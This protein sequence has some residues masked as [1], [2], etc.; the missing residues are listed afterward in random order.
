MFTDTGSTHVDLGSTADTAPNTLELSNAELNTISGSGTTFIGVVAENA[1]VVTHAINLGRPADKTLFLFGAGGISESGAGSVTV[2][3][4]DLTAIFAVSMTGAN[5]VSGIMGGVVS[6][7][8][9]P[10]T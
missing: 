3:N 7:S 9:Q 10:F 1:V 4:L 6:G 5:V 8:S 2:K